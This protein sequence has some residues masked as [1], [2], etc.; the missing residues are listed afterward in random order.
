[1]EP[2]L[3][4]VE[5][6]SN[7]G[8]ILSEYLELKGYQ[9]SWAKDGQE[10]LLSFYDARFDMCILDIMLPKIDGFELAR[11][12]R[13]IDKR[14]PII[15]LT[16]KSLKEDTVKGLRLGADDYITKP[17]SM[18]ELLLRVKAILR[19]TTRVNKTDDLEV[20]KFGD[21]KFDV[22]RQ[23]LI[24]GNETKRLTPKESGLLKLL[25]EHENKT[26]YRNV[27]LQNVWGDDNYFNA[28]SMD[29]YITKLRKYLKVDEKVKI[30]T[31]HGQGF[32]LVNAF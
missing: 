32:K 22:T 11:K 26:L 18:E 17:F 30:L 27:A 10:G 3:L 15:F 21:F 7:L 20:Y 4:V 31:I 2:R 28:R 14:I 6:D 23:L 5:D 25:C 29:V 16:S 1:M 24:N 13:L 8:S 12:I 19:R 9:T